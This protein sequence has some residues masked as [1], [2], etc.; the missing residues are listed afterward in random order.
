MSDPNRADLDDDW[1]EAEEA[2]RELREG[3]DRV[4]ETVRQARRRFGNDNDPDQSP[5]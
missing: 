1:A 3:L 2:A 5:A 4:R